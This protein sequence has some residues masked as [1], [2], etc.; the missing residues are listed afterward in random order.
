MKSRD[1]LAQVLELLPQLTDH[2]LQTVKQHIG[3]LSQFVPKA[4]H[5]DWLLDGIMHETA[6]RGLSETIP[7]YFKIK[8]DSSY[9]GY[10]Q[11]AERIRATFE[12][13]LPGMSELE[14]QA[15][16]RLAARVLAKHVSAY[17]GLSFGTL[18]ASVHHIPEAIDAAFPGYL[19][20]G[21]M[22]FVI[23]RD[24]HADK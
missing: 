15:L 4:T 17:R 9:A 21:M 19:A 20:N 16:G 5:D 1:A 11:K 24:E 10:A 18:L 8:N 22:K 7:R 3:A 13:V 2:G 6:N 23:R 12:T 14:L